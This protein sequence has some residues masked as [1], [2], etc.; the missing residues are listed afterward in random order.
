MDIKSIGKNITTLRKSNSYTQESLAEKLNLSPQAISKWETGAGLPEASVLIILAD[1]FG[2]TIDKILR[3]HTPGNTVTNFISRNTAVPENKTL[4]NIPRISRWN[5]PE[6]CDMPY[7]FPAT[8]ATAL[9]HIDAQE[10]GRA[11]ITYPEINERFRDIM[12]ITGMAYGFLWNIVSRHI[13]EELWHVN[14]IA[15]MVE[16]VMGYYGRDYL[17]LTPE[18][19]TIGEIRHLIKWSITQGRPL[20]M[21]WPGGIPEFNLVT[22]YADNADTLIGYTYCEECATKTNEQGMFVNP[23]RWGETWGNTQ[24]RALVIGNKKA[25]NITDRDTVAY[26]LTVLNKS[27]ADDKEFFLTHEYITGDAALQGWLAACDT[28]ENT[29]SLF[30]HDNIF[31]YFLYKN[32]AYAQNCIVT[33]YKKLAER[34]SRKVHDAVVQITLAIGKI[35]GEGEAATKATSDKDAN[36][37]ETAALCRRYIENFIKHREYLRGWLREILDALEE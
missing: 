10:Q 34:S 11:P 1:L 15:E 20:V 12:H 25:P 29:I 18:N 14:D 9:C 8:I 5:A 37:A 33:Y 2:V 31:N 16:R 24:F 36:I 19:C 26:T 22:G 17:W 27:T 3:P 23:A 32:S 13:I 7:S 30:R 35:T 6:G 21:E 28:D 4:D